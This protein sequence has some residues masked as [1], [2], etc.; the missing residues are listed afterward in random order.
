MNNLNF[1]ETKAV[2]HTSI[3]HKSV[4]P[5][6]MLC[7]RA[8]ITFATVLRLQCILLMIVRLRL[9]PQLAIKSRDALLDFETTL[10]FVCSS[11]ESNFVAARI[12]LSAGFQSLPSYTIC[13]LYGRQWTVSNL[14]EVCT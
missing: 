8:L 6:I 11:L 2:N 10:N 9:L 13:C 4:Y 12:T 3:L 14:I 5:M 7:L 1:C